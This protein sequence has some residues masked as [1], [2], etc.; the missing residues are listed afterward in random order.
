MAITRNTTESARN[1]EISRGTV[2]E[3][4]LAGGGLAERLVWEVADGLVFVCNQ[5]TFDRLERGDDAAMPIG[6][7]TSD[8]RAIA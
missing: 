3:V 1:T 6:F 2:V 4:D 8:V 5:K 7:P